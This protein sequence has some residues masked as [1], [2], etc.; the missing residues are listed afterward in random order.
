M[1]EIKLFADK[2]I[3]HIIHTSYYFNV[4][5]DTAQK[6]NNNEKTI[7]LENHVNYKKM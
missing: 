1:H 2:P 5:H 4:T 7:K 6:Y 3:F